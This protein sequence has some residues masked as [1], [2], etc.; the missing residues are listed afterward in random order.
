M[1]F[2]Y[3]NDADS[4]VVFL[5]GVEPD[6]WRIPGHRKILSNANLVFRALMEGPLATCE[7]TIIVEDVEGRAFDY[8]LRYFFFL[9][10]FS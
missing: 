1:D 6:V 5:V 4:D 8:L 10:L 7:N 9:I 2:L 3:D